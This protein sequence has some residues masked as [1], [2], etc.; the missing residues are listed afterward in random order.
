M[1]W[2]RGQRLARGAHPH[3]HLGHRLESPLRIFI[4]PDV[5]PTWM[6]PFPKIRN[7]VVAVVETD[8]EPYSGT[9]SEGGID[10]RDIY[11]NLAASMMMCE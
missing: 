4:H 11:I 5:K 3:G 7:R 6:D 10:A 9:L 2:A 1:R 8:M